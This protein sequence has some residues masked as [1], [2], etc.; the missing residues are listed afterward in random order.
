MRTT[1]IHVLLGVWVLAVSPVLPRDAAEGGD[2]FAAYAITEKGDFALPES[3]E[4]IEDKHL[5]QVRWGSYVG[6]QRRIAVLEVDNTSTVAAF[7]MTGPGGEAFSFSGFSP[8][9][10]V[11]VNGIE[12]MI[13]DSLARSGRFRLVERVAVGSV[14]AEQDLATEGR[15]TEE[16]GAETGQ[17]LGAEYFVQAVVT[18]YEP[19]FKGKKGGG[20]GIASAFTGGMKWGKSKSLV[21]MNFRLIDA[22]TSEVVFTKQVDVITTASKFH[23]DASSWGSDGAL[24]GF[25]SSYSS[26]PVGQAVMSAVNQGVYELIKQ[27]G[28]APAQGSVIK[29]DGEK[30]YVNLGD[31]VVNTGEVLVASKLGEDLIDPETGL[32]LGGETEEVGKIEV[33]TVRE[34]YSI[35]RPLG[36][37]G[38][39]LGRGDRVTSTSPPPPIHFAGRWEGPKK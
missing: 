35:A 16:S 7:Q 10:Q 33:V 31:D 6:P 30:I 36:F 28:A 34:K 29:A 23:A 25:L 9:G 4:G 2:D 12:S 13:T 32:S 19:D 20:S 39:K 3:V 22:E 8:T 14:L 5:V 15:T 26:T 37:D 24:G 38:G 18:S 21:G 27:I 11:P 17:I 1:T